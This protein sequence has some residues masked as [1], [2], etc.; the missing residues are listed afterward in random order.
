MGDPARDQCEA[1]NNLKTEK[2]L[3][4]LPDWWA[5]GSGGSKG[6]SAPDRCAGRTRRGLSRAARRRAPR[7]DWDRAAIRGAPDWTRSAECPASIRNPV[8]V[9]PVTENPSGTS[10]WIFLFGHQ[11]KRKK[12]NKRT[13]RE[14]GENVRIRSGRRLGIFD[15][16]ARNC[17]SMSRGGVINDASPAQFIVARNGV[18]WVIT[19]AVVINWFRTAGRH[20]D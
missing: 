4:S 13:K 16:A 2:T 15:W 5:A 7:R 20:R 10:T 17:W 3:R 12:T 8:C 14:A 11:K 6:L 19:G 18:A 1:R 9:R